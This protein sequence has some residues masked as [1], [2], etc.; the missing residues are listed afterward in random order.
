MSRE[1]TPGRGKLVKLVCTVEQFRPCST[2]RV[3][4]LD[5]DRDY[6][7][8]EAFWP[9]Q[10]PLTRKIWD[11]AREMGYRYC[12]IVE[13]GRI[14]S[15]AAEYRYSDDAWMVAAVGTAPEYRRRGYAKAVVSF[16][17]GGILRA[18]RL[19]TCST[20]EDNMAMIRTAESVGFRLEGK[21]DQ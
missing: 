1:R 21:E 4:W 17:T 6:S 10:F 15:L 14:A 20:R 13:E 2:A 11:E 16:V 5:W 18:G 7:L 9:V 19:A 12:A 3:R 8:A